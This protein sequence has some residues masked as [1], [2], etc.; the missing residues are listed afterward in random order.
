MTCRKTE[1]SPEWKMA[2]A[3]AVGEIFFNNLERHSRHE[4][5]MCGSLVT[6]WHIAKPHNHHLWLFYQWP[7]CFCT[8]GAKIAVVQLYIHTWMYI[9]MQICIYIYIY[10]TYILYI[11][12]YVYICVCVCMYIYLKPMTTTFNMMRWSQGSDRNGVAIKPKLCL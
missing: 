7:C 5:K 9:N 4:W 11:C 3:G 12:T 1:D 8:Q 10:I 2:I 6:Q